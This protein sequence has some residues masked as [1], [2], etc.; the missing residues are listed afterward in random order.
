MRMKWKAHDSTQLYGGGSV[1]QG[2]AF[3]F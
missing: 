1:L 3:S 2:K